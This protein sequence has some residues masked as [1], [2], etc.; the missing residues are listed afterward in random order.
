MKNNLDL[1][2]QYVYITHILKR[3]RYILDEKLDYPSFLLLPTYCFVNVTC[4]FIKYSIILATMGIS[5]L[6]DNHIIRSMDSFY[7]YATVPFYLGM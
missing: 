7:F 6:Y 2:I 1:Y 5:F 4:H 3:L